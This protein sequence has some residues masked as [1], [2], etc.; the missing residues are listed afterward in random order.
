[1]FGIS[2]HISAFFISTASRL[3]SFGVRKKYEIRFSSSSDNG[4]RLSDRREN[5]SDVQ[6]SQTEECPLM[7]WSSQ[8]L[9]SHEA[10]YLEDGVCSFALVCV[11]PL[12]L[13][14]AYTHTRTV[15]IHTHSWWGPRESCVCVCGS[16]PIVGSWL[17]VDE[18]V[19]LELV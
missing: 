9:S 1:M 5:L 19:F 11:C 7:S 6:H 17:A 8:N 3:H 15:Y 18:R 10:V 12:C 13:P 2:V 4:T 14:L 16:V